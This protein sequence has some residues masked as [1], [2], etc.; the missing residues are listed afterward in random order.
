MVCGKLPGFDRFTN[1]VEAVYFFDGEGR[2]NKERRVKQ[3]RVEDFAAMEIVEV[4]QR[5]QQP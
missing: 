3:P 1:L 4:I 5:Q 2:V